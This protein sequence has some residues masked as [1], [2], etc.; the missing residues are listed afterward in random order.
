MFSLH[1]EK[2]PGPDGYTTHFFK[3]TWNVIGANVTLAIEWVL[4][5]GK[6]PCQLSSTTIALILKKKV[7]DTKKD[8][9]PISCYNTL[10]KCIAKLLSNR[11]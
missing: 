9:R 11:L 6:L 10:Y 8:Y 1:G 3:A 2:S 4:K 7:Y 5:T